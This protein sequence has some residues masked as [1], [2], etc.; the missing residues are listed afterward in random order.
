MR[1]FH[2][3]ISLLLLNVE[4]EGGKGEGARSL[5]SARS[6]IIPAGAIVYPEELGL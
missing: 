1:S 4:V 5:S 3:T 2:R 6:F